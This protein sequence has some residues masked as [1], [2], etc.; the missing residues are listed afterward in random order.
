[1]TLYEYE[2]RIAELQKLIMALAEKLAVCSEE[3]SRLA[4]KN[5]K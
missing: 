4:E 3:L 2:D 5:Q 1:M